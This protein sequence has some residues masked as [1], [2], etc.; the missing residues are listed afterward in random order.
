MLNLKQIL[1][2]IAAAATLAILV[3]TAGT[4]QT[5]NVGIKTT[6]GLISEEEVQ[7]LY[8]VLSGT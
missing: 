1:L 8:D 7:R 3:S 2:P 5:G 6:L 4:I